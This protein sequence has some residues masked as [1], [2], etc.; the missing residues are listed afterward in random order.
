[1]FI[2]DTVF[3][4]KIDT[5]GDLDVGEGVAGH[6]DQIGNLALSDHAQVV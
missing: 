3:H 2:D 6:G 4:D 1:M 5:T